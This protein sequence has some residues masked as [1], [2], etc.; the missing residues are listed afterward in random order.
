MNLVRASRYSR[1]THRH[2][3][4][5]LVSICTA[6]NESRE[7]SNRL[8]HRTG[9]GRIPTAIYEADKR[10]FTGALAVN[11]FHNPIFLRGAI[12][13]ASRPVPNRPR[14]CASNTSR[15]II[16]NRQY[17]FPPIG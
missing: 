13:A 11:N 7:T 9:H 15:P 17:N 1:E 10:R 14:R 2:H 5:K 6:L 4:D 3:R 12:Q 8:A 16:K